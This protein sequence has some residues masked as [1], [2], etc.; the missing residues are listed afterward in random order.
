MVDFDEN[1]MSNLAQS[2][3]FALDHAGDVPL[4]VQLAWRIRA[5]VSTGR[6]RAGERLPSLRKVAQWAGVNVNTVR[7]V[8]E[9]LEAE[10]LIASQHGRG[11]FVAESAAAE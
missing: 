9:S 10:G 2:N 3:P 11:T 8:Y 6:L 5:L 4:G 7:A 1:C